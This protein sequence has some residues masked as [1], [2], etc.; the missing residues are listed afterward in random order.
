MDLVRFLHVLD[1]DEVVVDHVGPH[2][3]LDEVGQQVGFIPGQSA[4]GPAVG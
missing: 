4:G 3:D 2:V 1:K